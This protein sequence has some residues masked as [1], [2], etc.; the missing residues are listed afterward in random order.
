MSEEKA[1]ESPEKKKRRLCN[2]SSSA[3]SSWEGLN[4]EILSL[5][6]V[7]ISADELCRSVPFVCRSWREA[8]AGPYCWADVDV[9]SWCRRCGNSDVINTAVRK[10]VRR[11]RGTLR[12][13]S[14]YKL[15]DPAFSFVANLS[16]SSSV[17]TFFSTWGVEIFSSRCWFIHWDEV[18]V[19]FSVLFLNVCYLDNSFRYC[20]LWFWDLFIC[21]WW[22]C[23]RT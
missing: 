16:V 19:L 13:L 5:I 9:V 8:V 20:R 10:L 14:A 7:R 21:G 11:S 22:E 6:F 3:S 2:S 12:S 1:E 15:G 17:S 4:P 18:A 23:G